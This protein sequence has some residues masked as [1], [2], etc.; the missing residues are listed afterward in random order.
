MK[1]TVYI[2]GGDGFARE[3]YMYLSSIIREDNTIEFG[4]FLG[5]NGYGE[6]VDYK[7]LQHLYKGDVSEH[8]FLEN[9]YAVIG[10]GFPKLRKIIYEDLKMRN[11]KFYTLISKDSCINEFVEY[12]E[13]NIFIYYVPSPDVKIGNGNLFNGYT[14]TGHDV[15]IGD[16]NFFAPRAQILGGAKIGS[17]NTIGANAILLP[18]AKIGD[19]NKIA[20]LSAV[21]KGCRNNCY[22]AGNPAL[23]IG[24][25]ENN[26]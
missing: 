16:F 24:S 6:T 17:M 21:Y 8:V 25:T 23:K 9:E 13:A 12:G 11:I 15:E 14:I 26:D 20:P 22:M 7:K 5:H 3:C 18:K 4:G 2:V 10:A 1:K 19:N